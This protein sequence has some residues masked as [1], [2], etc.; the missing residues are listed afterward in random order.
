MSR[1]EFVAPIKEELPVFKFEYD[2]PEPQPH[3]PVKKMSQLERA[4]FDLVYD[5][6]EL[7]KNSAVTLA[8][9]K[10]MEVMRKFINNQSQEEQKIKKI[11]EPE[12]QQME[13][14]DERAESMRHLSEWP[15]G[16]HL[17]LGKVVFGTTER[18]FEF[19]KTLEEM[20]QAHIEEKKVQ[21]SEELMATA[22]A[23]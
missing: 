3:K 1:P 6:W 9:K 10:H 15:I 18:Q 22:A 7:E 8:K 2:E 21:A 23:Q 19:E 13:I 17:V 16:K 5:D 20:H 14:E 12:W 11:L 4:N